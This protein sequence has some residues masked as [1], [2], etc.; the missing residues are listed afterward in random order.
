[1]AT[2][3]L[4]S[5]EED[6]KEYRRVV[7]ETLR[8]IGHDLKAMEDYVAA[9][10]R[11]VE[12]CLKDVEEADIYVGLFAFRYGYIPP[13]QHQNA[14]G[15][16][17]SE[18]EY[19]HARGHGKPCL[20]FLATKGCG[21]HLDYVDACTG[22]GD[23]GERIK[24]LREHLMT[25]NL[26]SPFSAPHELSTLVL[27]AVTKHLD[28]HKQPESATNRKPGGPPAITWD[29]E[30]QGSPYPGLF[31]FTRRYAPVSFGRGREICEIL[32]RLREPEGRFLLISGASGSGKSSLVDA[33]VLPRIEQDG[34]TGDR[35]YRCV[36]MVPSQGNHPFDALLRPLHSYA[37]RARMDPYQLAEQL[38]RE[39]GTL[40]QRIQN[41]VAKGLDSDGLVLFVDQM[42]ELFTVRDP[43]QSQ[44]F[45]SALYQA[46]QD[47]S[48]HVIATIRSDFL[49]Y[50][51]EHADLLRVLNGRGYIGL[52]PID[53]NSISEMISKPA[54]CAGLKISNR[55]ARRLVEE[56]GQGRSLP[57]LAFVLQQLFENRERGSNEL[58]E[59][60]FDQ[61]GGLAVRFE[62]MQQPSK[63]KSSNR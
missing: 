49:P 27:A 40:A 52:G 26:A 62:A 7:D 22:N 46:A 42:E 58:T 36:R 39:P 15:V 32:D 23:R 6:L 13:M 16:S 28:E 43:A 21:I 54:H 24:A 48:L 19:R 17:I 2:I 12:K 20:A 31:P 51:H 8:K 9:D 5:T 41:I 37:E 11:P 57:L 47:A 50:C 18:M 29:I 4:S 25:E 45:L 34:I 44:A 59:K 30:T 38:V 33:G 35:K 56:A 1:M 53:G 60:S 61:L 55:L 14:D 10:Q 63:A 3:Y